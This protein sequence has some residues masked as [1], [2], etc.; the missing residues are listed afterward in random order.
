[1]PLET[2]NV[3]FMPP[4]DKNVPFMPHRDKKIVP[5][6]PSRD[7]NVSFIPPRDKKIAPF[8]SSQ[9]KKLSFLSLG[10]IKNT[11]KKRGHMCPPLYCTNIKLL[12]NNQNNLRPHKNTS[13]Q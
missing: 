12:I 9:D 10:G 13:Q 8:M 11:H 3:P 5:F 7:K 1:M 2:K 6:M 4:K